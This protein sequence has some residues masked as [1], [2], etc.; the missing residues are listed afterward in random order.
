MKILVFADF[1]SPHARGWAD[2]VE[3]AGIN[4]IRVS[5]ELTDAA[6]TVI[7]PAD[8]LAKLR[9]F[10]LRRRQQSTKG[11]HGSAR[12]SNHRDIPENLH[13]GFALLRFPSRAV[14]LRRL[15]KVHQPDIVHALR[16][17]YEGV[18]ALT[19]GLPTPVVVSTWGQDFIPQ[20]ASSNVLSTWMR[21]ALRRAAGLHNDS[22]ID[23]SRSRFFGFREGQETLFAAG[24]FGVDGTLFYPSEKEKDAGHVVF[25][26]GPQSV[27]NGEKFI[28]AVVELAATP[29]LRFTAVGL[30]G[31]GYAEKAM[32][33]PS[34]QGRLTLTPKLSLEDFA[35]IVRS[36][37]VVVSPATSD[38]TPVSL[39]S[40]LAAGV[41]VVAGNIPS[42]RHLA[43]A[44]SSLYLVDPNSAEDIAAEVL[45]VISENSGKPAV[46]PEAFSIEAN[47][48]R[49]PKFY[50]SVLR[51]RN[52][53]P[54]V[55]VSS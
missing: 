31:V 13:A 28:E 12:E 7:Q 32:A 1:R 10:L 42:I 17:P 36:A 2:G 55:Q 47:L 50:E 33:M 41:P 16:L 29:G 43:T 37:A 54:S 27:A 8:V 44:V 24:N 52:Q 14:Q 25:P 39:L 3:Q 4:V 11:T 22:A 48:L 20:A 19:I 18:T 21:V 6:G 46:L 5:S 30:K 9:R 35:R 34:L 51:S 23:E 15:V 40:A 26:R 53:K 49:V 38:G 45:R